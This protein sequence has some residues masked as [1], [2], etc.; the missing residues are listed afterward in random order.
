MTGV[1]ATAR[2]VLHPEMKLLLDARKGEPPPRSIQEKRRQWT[3]YTRT[4]AQPAPET[5]RVTDQAIEAAHRSVPV[6]IYRHRSASG[7]QPCII[8]MHGGGFQLGDLDS[9]DAIAW[10][11]EGSGATVISIDYRLAPEHPWPAAFDDCHGVLAWLAAHP[12]E[13][14]IDAARIALAGDSAGGRLAAGMSIKARDEGGP[15]IAA[16]ALV[17]ASAGALPGSRSMVEFADGYGLTATKYR[18]FYKAL[19][20]DATYENDPSAWPIRA[21]DLAR[22]PPTLVHTAEIDPIRDDGRAFASRLALA[23]TETLFREAKGM[24]HGFM[25]ARFHG[26]AAKAEFD[27][28][29]A[30]LRDKLGVSHPAAR[31]D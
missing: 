18:D 30:F 8:Y 20:P 28:I 29:C 31:L 27:F 14:G 10:G 22:L 6:R 17:Y 25:R 7:P 24:I 19:F 4:L 11:F 3:A 16:Q 1:D 15:A 23:G 26:P 12:V 2:P 9:S 5:L 13:L 21:K